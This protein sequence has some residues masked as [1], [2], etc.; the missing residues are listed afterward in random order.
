MLS[1]AERWTDT[2]AGGAAVSSLRQAVPAGL[3]RGLKN[4]PPLRWT[5][6]NPLSIIRA[7]RTL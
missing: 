3:L 6:P 7:L 1:T 4:R 2:S 5:L